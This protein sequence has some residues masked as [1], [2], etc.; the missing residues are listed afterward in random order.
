MVGAVYVTAESGA[1]TIGGTPADDD[2]IFFRVS[3]DVSDANDDMTED[4]RLIGIKLFY[5]TDN[6]T[7]A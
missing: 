3:R 1:V 7:D 5:T 2:L 6:Y 4:A